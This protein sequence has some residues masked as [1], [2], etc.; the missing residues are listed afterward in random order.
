[1]SY[2]NFNKAYQGSLL[3]KFITKTQ[4]PIANA[5]RN[6]YKEAADESKIFKDVSEAI[7]GINGIKRDDIIP[8]AQLR[9]R[10]AI[11]SKPFLSKMFKEVESIPDV[12]TISLKNKNINPRECNLYG[13]KLGFN[14]LAYNLKGKLGDIR[15]SNPKYNWFKSKGWS[16]TI[17]R[18]PGKGHL[19]GFV[20]KL[21]DDRIKE[22]YCLTAQ[23]NKNDY[24]LKPYKMRF[25]NSINP[26]SYLKSMVLNVNDL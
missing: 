7:L 24:K 19:V 17:L 6:Y 15:T 10:F 11:T 2:F 13:M 20:F 9:N 23:S 12:L 25:I 8:E 16:C 22:V 1:M 3:Q 18:P 5:F 21:D 26:K 4:A 14:P